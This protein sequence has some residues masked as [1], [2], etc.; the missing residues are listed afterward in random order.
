MSSTS[1]IAK[2]QLGDQTYEL[3]VR[4][5]TEGNRAIDISKLYPMT[6]H[7]TLDDGYGNTGSTMSTI[8]YVDGEAGVLRYRGYAV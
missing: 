7:I 6:K 8:T 1:E 5:G 3:P 4:V 2:L